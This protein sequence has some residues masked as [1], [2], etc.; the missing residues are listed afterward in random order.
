MALESVIQ[1]IG[2]SDKKLSAT[3]LSSLSDMDG[4]DTRAL[5]DAWP[6]VEVN[7][8]FAIIQ[9]A[10]ELAQDNV[11]LNFDAIFKIALS[12]EEATV[13]AAALRGLSE[14]ERR[15]L[16]PVLIDLLL[17]DE[18]AGVRREAAVVLGRYAL[19][20]ELG[21]FGV[22]EERR[23][24][25]ALIE[26]AEDTEEDERVRARAIE[27]LGALSGEDTDNLIESI[28]DEDSLWLKVGAV[29]A[30]GRSAN[31]IWV[32]LVLRETENGAPEMRHAAAFA[33]GE[34]G[35]EEA[36]PRLRRM[37]IEDPDREVKLAAVHSLGEIG[38][39]TARVALQG[40][41][42]EGGDDLEEAVNEALEEIAF[43]ED[44]FGSL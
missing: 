28:Y 32:P 34:I 37:A 16:I 43:N 7:R 3:Q 40:V 20:C 12:D 13:R 2:D 18:D 25:Q 30:M 41:L 33:L 17:T 27:A 22:E 5:T 42:Y 15:D 23:V 35:E 14:Y 6:E 38:G 24:R 9:Q 1:E 21:Q 11:D 10:T 31:A 8:R 44:P 29:D 39:S 19:A 4:D 36:I 26:S